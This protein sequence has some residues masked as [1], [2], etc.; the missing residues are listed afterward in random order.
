MKN[1]FYCFWPGCSTFHFTRFIQQTVDLVEEIVGWKACLCFS[2]GRLQSL[3]LPLN[4]ILLG[5]SIP[6]GLILSLWGVGLVPDFLHGL[7]QDFS[8]TTSLC[9]SAAPWIGPRWVRETF[10]VVRHFCQP[11]TRPTQRGGPGPEGCLHLH[12]ILYWYELHFIS[13]TWCHL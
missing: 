9:L 7:V 6:R 5:S 10:H 1:L 13:T 11:P 12:S 4:L 8:A 3:G 2:V